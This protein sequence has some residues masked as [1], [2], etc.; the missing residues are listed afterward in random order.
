MI[1]VDLP[2]LQAAVLAGARRHARRSGKVYSRRHLTSKQARLLELLADGDGVGFEELAA[3]F[4]AEWEGVRRA[5]PE[6]SERVNRRAFFQNVADLAGRINA[7]L[8]AGYS[9]SA[10][11]ARLVASLGGRYVGFAVSYDALEVT[12]VST[13]DLDGLRSQVHLLDG[14]EHVPRRKRNVAPVGCPSPERSEHEAGCDDPAP[15]ESVAPVPPSLEP[16]SLACPATALDAVATEPPTLP[17]PLPEPRPSPAPVKCE[18]LEAHVD[19]VSRRWVLSIRGLPVDV[20]PR[21][22]LLYQNGQLIRWP[23][24]PLPAD[25]EAATP[26]QVR[27]LLSLLE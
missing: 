5:H 10:L 6:R 20:D 22:G 14:N 16:P 4:A 23:G 8:V 15:G 13:E 2:A 19:C 12:P 7:C 25:P 21:L 9:E 18:P 24:D 11:G 26:A 27:L 17:D 1:P 3:A